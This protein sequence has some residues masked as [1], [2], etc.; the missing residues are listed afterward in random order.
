[1]SLDALDIIIFGIGAIVGYGVKS[2]LVKQPV[3]QKGAANSNFSTLSTQQDTD[4]KQHA[5]DTFFS[6]ANITLTQAEVLIATLRSQLSSSAAELSSSH[7]AEN[8][9]KI[10]DDIATVEQS[11]VE[12]PLDYAPKE[13]TD[14]PGTLSEEFGF[15]QDKKDAETTKEEPST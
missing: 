11:I 13:S 12:P 15:S 9:N 7:L 1:M 6:D 14:S 10:I 8:H 4:K 2:Y 3:E 5:I